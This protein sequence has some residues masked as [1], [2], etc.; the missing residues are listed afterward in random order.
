MIQAKNGML[1]A[2]DK[3]TGNIALPHMGQ[4]QCGHQQTGKGG[5]ALPSVGNR[6]IHD[7]AVL[8]VKVFYPYA[9]PERDGMQLQRDNYSLCVDPFF[10]WGNPANL[11]GK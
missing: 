4:R 11:C 6:D 5:K 2:S 10:P 9:N 3:T 7:H 8:W 1:E